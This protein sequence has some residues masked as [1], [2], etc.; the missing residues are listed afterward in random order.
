MTKICSDQEYN[1]MGVVIATKGRRYLLYLQL[2]LSALETLLPKSFKGAV[3]AKNNGFDSVRLQRFLRSL[4]GRRSF[5]PTITTLNCRVYRTHIIRG[6]LQLLN[7]QEKL[8]SC[9]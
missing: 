9:A 3:R 1:D 7:N 5:E 8:V 4:V 2:Y 6:L